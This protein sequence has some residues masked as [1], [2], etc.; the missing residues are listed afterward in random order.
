M[1]DLSD[2]RPGGFH[3]ALDQEGN[4]PH[5]GVCVGSRLATSLVSY[6]AHADLRWSILDSRS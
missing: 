1:R 2:I 4:A 3:A 5:L 6:E